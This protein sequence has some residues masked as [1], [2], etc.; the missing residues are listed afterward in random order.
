MLA[1]ESW[2][3]ASPV[4]QRSIRQASD[5]TNC[6]SRHASWDA[7][8]SDHRSI[9]NCDCTHAIDWEHQSWLL[10]RVE[11]RQQPLCIFYWSW[12]H[13]QRWDYWHHGTRKRFG[14]EPLE[15]LQDRRHHSYLN[16]VDSR[17]CIETWSEKQ[18]DSWR[19]RWSEV[20]WVPRCPDR[21]QKCSR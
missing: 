4:F 10:P 20:Q 13:R 7:L 6:Y 3:F 8:H 11:N 16:L 19:H 18:V 9:L 21:R 17:W 14:E 2:R 1:V 5:H 15:R 12:I